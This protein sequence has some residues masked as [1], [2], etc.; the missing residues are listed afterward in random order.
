MTDYK[1]IDTILSE[2]ILGAKITDVYYD[3]EE[4]FI[5]L[6]NG[7]AIIV[8]DA[9]GSGEAFNIFVGRVLGDD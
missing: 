3:G 6:D 2:K 8:E 4:L 5:E 1:Y 7:L 9:N